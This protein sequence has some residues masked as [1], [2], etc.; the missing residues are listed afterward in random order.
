M[1]AFAVVFVGGVLWLAL[2]A[3]KRPA[4]TG[5]HAVG[6]RLLTVV[7]PV[8]TGAFEDK[9][10]VHRE[11][12]VRV[13]YPAEPG[14][15]RQRL[16]TM[17]GRVS[18]AFAKLYGF[19]A[20]GGD[21]PLSASLID[22]V[23][24]ASEKPYPVVVFSHGAFSELHQNF[25]TLQELA[26]QGFVAVSVG[27]TYESVLTLFADGRAVPIDS[28][29]AS[30]V[31][32][33]SR[34]PEAA[35]KDFESA[36]RALAAAENRENWVK[37]AYSLGEVYPNLF[38]SMQLKLRD[39]VEQRV[40]DLQLVLSA[41]ARWQED[42]EHPLS[43]LM[44]GERV[45]LIGHSLG[46]YVSLRLA[47]QSKTPSQAVV[48]LD[49][50]FF[51]FP[52]DEVPE[53]EAP[54]LSFYAEQTQIPGGQLARIAGVNRYLSQDPEREDHLHLELLGAT[55]MN[56]TDMNYLPRVM[57]WLGLLGAVDGAAASKT[58]NQV[59]VAFFQ[60]HLQQQATSW[61]AK[62]EQKFPNLRQAP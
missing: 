9:P 16:T 7:D 53:L 25:S 18:K 29:L 42:P 40:L 32:D 58:V 21:G 20:I 5:V 35:A 45:G 26:S 6:T 46:G 39:L 31:T 50:P 48:A 41:L 47:M 3:P 8:R 43:S 54:L 11:L 15:E 59:I 52:D 28:R 27:H 13:W 10:G 55:H 57:S 36:L 2:L 49:V 37:A 12:A 14:Q 22:A 19:P 56:F 62:P 61:L 38:G 33:L 24:L 23:P 34:A 30:A 51:L 4:L 60:Q 1:L 17:D 44:D